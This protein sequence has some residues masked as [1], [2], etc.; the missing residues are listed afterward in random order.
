MVVMKALT[1]FL[2]IFLLPVMSLPQNIPACDS[3]VIE[4]CPFEVDQNTVTLIASNYSSYLFDYPGFILFNSDM[5][6]VAIETVN[7]FG[8]STNQPHWLNIIHPFELPFDG[9]LE[10]YVLFYDSLTC[11]FEITIPD[12]VTSSVKDSRLTDLRIFPNP[13]TDQLNIAFSSSEPVADIDMRIVNLLSQEKL[14]HRL[15]A[16]GMQI[17]ARMIGEPGLYFIQITDALGH[18]LE[19]RK[20]LLR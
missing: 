20:L 11:T 2:I 4:C 15:T 8:I 3:L 18:I 10:L 7:Y 12:T 5:D 9:I 1:L 16:S 14:K 19:T 13:V 17:P 6:T